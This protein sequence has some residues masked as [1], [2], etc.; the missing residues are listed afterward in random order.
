MFLINKINPLV[1]L[2]SLCIGL[3]F[4]YIFTPQPDIIIKYPTPE[5]ANN[6]VYK[7]E[8]DNCF[9]FDSKQVPCP[10]DISKILSI[11]IQNTKSNTN[12]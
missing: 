2:L 1:F 10:K 4:T 5:T 9:K 3:F 12:N 8:A 7:D 6:T 11:P